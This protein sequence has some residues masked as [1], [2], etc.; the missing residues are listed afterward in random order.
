MPSAT[1][2]RPKKPSKPRR[3]PPPTEE[4]VHELADA[5][6]QPMLRGFV[7]TAAYSGLR[8][9]EVCALRGRDVIR[10][11]DKVVLHVRH[12]KGD[13]ER[14]SLLLPPAHDAL[15]LLD[16]RGHVF[17]NGRGGEWK[18][19]MIREHWGKVRRRLG[20]NHVWFHDLRKF[21]ASQLINMGVSDTDMAIQLGHFDLYGR[22]N[23][24]LVRRVYAYLDHGRCLDRIVSVYREGSK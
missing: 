12:G 7:L 23:T 1:M 4:Q 21:H 14:R 22:P 17:V 11:G 24:E 18:T 3:V 6:P 13:K 8:V 5:M 19:E 10:D 20:L 15:P 9:S 16:P 2:N